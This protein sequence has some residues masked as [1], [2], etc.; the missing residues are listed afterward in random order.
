VGVVLGLLA[1]CRA[2]SRDV[3]QPVTASITIDSTR[4]FQTF[5]GWE[6][7]AQGG[8]EEA[9]S[10]SVYRDSLVDLAVN[11][12]GITRVR[13]WLRSGF[14]K[15]IDV[16]AQ[17]RAGKHP[18]FRCSRFT[19]VNDNNDPQ[20]INPAG[21]H[22]SQLDY[23]M[24]QLVLPMKRLVEANGEKFFINANYVAFMKL[25]P[26]G[27]RY[28]HVT[29]AEYAEFVLAAYQHLQK[30]YGIVPDAWEVILEP[31]NTYFWQGR[32]IGE[33]IVATAKLLEKHG[34][35]PRFI[36]P[37]TTKAGNAPIYF[38]EMVKV[39]GVVPYLE[40][41]SYHRYRGF[42]KDDFVAIANRA[43]RYHIK[44]SMLEHIG[45]GYRD[46][47]EDLKVAGVSAWQQ[48]A[49]AYPAKDDDG[50]QYYRVENDGSRKAKLV[51]GRRTRYLRQYFRYIR[52]GSVRV[53]A[54]SNIPEV[55]AVAFTGPGQRFVVVIKSDAPARMTLSGMP[56]A[57]YAAHYTTQ[58]ETDV[59]ATD[60]RASATSV[61]V[62]IPG[63]GVITVFSQ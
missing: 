46:L 23:T 39:N 27:A 36:A 8:Q 1:G 51:M 10:F 40:E 62:S 59:P 2:P 5:T 61:E 13:L 60:L 31:E 20:R 56:A 14:E 58:R 12:L 4:R 17:L 3:A 50:A 19:T 25:C 30:K 54:D 37:S 41:L 26:T 63:A 24:E 55:D 52:P 57:K 49:L 18:E 53:Q 9:A 28:D 38:D 44:T 11:D 42:S 29:P 47:H 34:F 6:V 16:W 43:A 32:Q 22:F 33:A 21:F 35:K 45:S 7:T 48:F 15:D